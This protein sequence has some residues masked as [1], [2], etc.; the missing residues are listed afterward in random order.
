MAILT[1]IN[2]LFTVD[3]TGAISFNRI[4]PSTTTGYTFPALD[5]TAN[6]ILKTNGNGILAWEPDAVGMED[7]IIAGDTGATTTIQ[8]G[9]T[10]TIA[11]GTN[12][13]TA[14]SG[15][16]VTINADLTGYVQGN[17]IAT[18]VAFWSASDTIS[19]NADLYWDNVNDRLGIGVGSAPL[20]K[21]NVQGTVRIQTNTNYY[22]DRT[23]LGDA[24]TFGAAEAADGVS[25]TINGAA[26]ATAGN[27]FRWLTQEGAATPIERMRITSAGNVG[28]GTSPGSNMLYV[29]GT[30]SGADVTTRFAPASNNAS[31]TFFLSSVSSGDGGYF[32]NSNN[33]TSGLFSYGDYTFY[34]GTG[35]LSGSGPA[36][37]RMTIL[38]GG[39][40]GIGTTSPQELLDVNSN[41]T[42]LNVDNTVA[43]F[44][45]DVGTT[46]SRDTW[47]KMRASAATTDYS[48]AFGTQQAGDFRFNYLGT[49][50]TAPTS[51]STR[52]T[53]NSSGSVTLNTTAA[54][55]SDGGTLRFTSSNSASASYVGT[56]RFDGIH[57]PSGTIY[58]GPSINAVKEDAN[59][60]TALTFKT[61]S[62]A[63]AVVENMRIDDDG[64]VGIEVTSPF[65]KLQVGT[66][67]FSGG[68]GMHSDGRVGI[69]NHGSLTGL[70]LASTY[71]D[72]TYPE[73]GLVFV[74]GPTTSSY[75]VWSISP[76]GPA[77]GSGLCFN[78]Q[79][80]STNVHDP[81]NTKVYLEGSTGY[82]GIGTTSP[83]AK[84]QVVGDVVATNFETPTTGYLYLGGHVRLNNP[85][86]GVF[87]LGQYNG[88]SWTDTLNITNA[89][90]GTFTG[91]VIAYSDKKLKK[92]IKTL[93]GSKVYKMRGVSFDR[94]DTGK[95]SSGVIAQ[96]IQKIA[97]ELISETDGTLGVAYGNISGYLIEAIKELKAE[98]EELK[99]KPCNCNNCNCK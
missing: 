27:Y 14:E 32:Y 53:I 51:G 36:N 82:V 66:N 42:G 50:A 9:D 17:G 87:K 19:S 95:A 13:T 41:V 44:G 28:I 74:Q 52:M 64:N 73:Y 85:G 59:Y 10:M 55:S 93:D 54:S 61:T 3:S 37:P 58:T 79:V 12:V 62:S 40:V 56:V 83:S 76:D 75:N 2:D 60:A 89:G 43:I 4:S 97:P 8:D 94:I 48:W 20:K 22:S 67:T 92:N 99:S 96:E 90:T 69:S 70:M 24:Y 84:L 57:T 15:G 23:Y 81:A 65:S 63:G 47:I 49:R 7:W 34:V 39:N 5:G 80:Q 30:T 77:K 25:Y 26:A 35:N 6:Y 38:Q 91:D 1:N 29:K 16:T 45:N 88:S 72:A 33:N 31:S 18:R 98:I 46:Q 78:Y 21:L 11:G 71:N 68:N 86:S